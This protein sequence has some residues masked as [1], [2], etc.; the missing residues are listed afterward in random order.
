MRRIAFSS[1]ALPDELSEQQKKAR[2]HESIEQSPLSETSFLENEPF[3]ASYFIIQVGDMPVST[4]NG[5]LSRG[6]RTHR[7]VIACPSDSF[8]FGFNSG[9][10]PYQLRQRRTLVS[11]PNA[12]ALI[13]HDET[14][15]ISANAFNSWTCIKIPRQQLV[16][17]IPNVEDL[18]MTPLDPSQPAIRHLQELMTFLSRASGG[19]EEPAIGQQIEVLLLDLM[20]LALGASRDIAEIATQRGLRMARLNK[21][22]ASIRARFTDPAFSPAAAGLA[23]G[24]SARYVQDLLHDTGQTFVERVQELRLQEA[25]TMLVDPR[26]AAMKMSDIAL[27]CGFGDQSYFNRCFRRRFGTTPVRYRNSTSGADEPPSS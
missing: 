4:F 11:E 2:W 25:R 13:S 10:T 8:G 7:A 12:A 26:N 27:S 24:V 19:L 9:R 16:A 1:D 14:C 20:T 17:R 5:T 15:E 6:T 21:I 3:S 23:M 18:I 22:L